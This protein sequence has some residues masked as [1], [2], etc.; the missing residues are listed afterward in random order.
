[1]AF[2]YLSSMKMEFGSVPATRMLAP[3]GMTF[4][5]LMNFSGPLA[6]KRN[7]QNLEL[8]HLGMIRIP[9]APHFLM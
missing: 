2:L 9:L 3:F 6:V 7:G 8:C 4:C 5:L 1:M